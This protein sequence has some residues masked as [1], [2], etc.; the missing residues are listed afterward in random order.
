MEKR[1]APQIYGLRG[2]A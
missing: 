1:R 2:L